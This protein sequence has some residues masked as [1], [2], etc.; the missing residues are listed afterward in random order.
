VLK[1]NRVALL[2]LAAPV[3]AAAFALTPAAA[4][5]LPCRVLAVWTFSRG[6]GSEKC[7][8]PPGVG[9][10]LQQNLRES[11]DG[12]ETTPVST[13]FPTSALLV[14]TTGA[15]QYRLSIGG[16]QEINEIGYVVLGVKL[17]HNPVS[18]AKECEVA[19]GSIPWFDGS[20]A[21]PA[22]VFAGTGAWTLSID[23]DSTACGERKG[24]VTIRNVGLLLETLGFGK[25]PIL[26]AGTLTGYY[27]QPS[28]E[29]ACPA[30]GIELE[31]K[32]P[33][34]T[35]EPFTERFEIDSGE[36][37]KPAS[38]CFVGANNYLFPKTAPTWAPFTNNTG[39]EKIGI[40]KD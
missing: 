21:T 14:D 24:L 10:E 37:G 29:T 32:Q 25:S 7:A 12:S 23:S 16:T 11:G 35:T 36:E 31:A 13:S 33:G 2:G 38:L 28:A 26:A 19:T 40:W 34:I 6:V 15:L 1:I 3:L 18:S 39:K 4:S 5:A 22:A 30:G 8:N 20:D 9:T 27:T 17:E